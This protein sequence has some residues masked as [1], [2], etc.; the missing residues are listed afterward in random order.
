MT[1]DCGLPLFSPEDDSLLKVH[2][3]ELVCIMNGLEK[4]SN[5]VAK[6][7]LPILFNSEIS[8]IYMVCKYF[9]QTIFFKSRQNGYS[10][11][12]Y[13][14]GKNYKGIPDELRNKMFDIL[15]DYDKNKG[16]YDKY[17]EEFILNLKKIL[18]KMSD[19][20][21]FNI[22]R[23]L[24]YVDNHK[25]IPDEH[26]NTLNKYIHYKNVDWADYYEIERISFEDR[27]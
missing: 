8:M 23:Q 15:K 2:F 4:G 1:S 19:N 12:F 17:P 10:K 14:I 5:F 24:Y 16:L 3:A 22:E 11:E 9:D 20:Y 25:N 18:V 13:I 21:M 7:V 27:L 6:F 26:Y